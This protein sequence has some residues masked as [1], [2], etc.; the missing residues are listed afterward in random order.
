MPT[1]KLTLIEAFEELLEEGA[2][3]ADEAGAEVRLEVVFRDE[4]GG[5][6]AV[7]SGPIGVVLA[8]VREAKAARLCSEAERFRDAPGEC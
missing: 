6:T 1:D 4:E 2:A 8:R 7:L 3:L 5:K